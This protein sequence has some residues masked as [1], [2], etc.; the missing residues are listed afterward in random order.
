VS[1][2]RVVNYELDGVE[3]GSRE[4][5]KIRYLILLGIFLLGMSQTKNF[6][7]DFGPK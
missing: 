3:K 7:S 5:I 6:V 4:Q 1:I 2:T